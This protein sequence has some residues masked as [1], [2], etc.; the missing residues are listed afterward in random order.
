M[1]TFVQTDNAFHGHF[2]NANGGVW[3]VLR[4][5]QDTA[6]QNNMARYSHSRYCSN[7]H[8]HNLSNTEIWEAMN[9][10][11]QDNRPNWRAQRDIA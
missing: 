11:F 7:I 8:F 9:S 6:T 2:L 3:T 5:L 4:L 10:T 1:R